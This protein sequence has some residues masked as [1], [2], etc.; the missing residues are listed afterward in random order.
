MPKQF[1]MTVQDNEGNLQDVDFTFQETDL[2]QFATV[3]D[4][5]NA[6]RTACAKCYRPDYPQE[7]ENF[8]KRKDD[9]DIP[10]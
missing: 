6:I 3:G 1:K 7:P 2:D 5:L 8:G 4:L 10:F 9:D